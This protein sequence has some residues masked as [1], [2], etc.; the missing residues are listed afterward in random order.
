MNEHFH[1]HM[2][3]HTHNGEVTPI[4]AQHVVSMREIRNRRSPF[5]RAHTH[6]PDIGGCVCI[7][8]GDIKA[9]DA[10]HFATGCA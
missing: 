10:K 3:A 5:H 4:I 2:H 7:H 9:I 8:M 1:T 6:K